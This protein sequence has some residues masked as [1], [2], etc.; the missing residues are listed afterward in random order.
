MATLCACGHN[1]WAHQPNCTACNSGI[2]RKF[3]A[4]SESED[5]ESDFEVLET[6]GAHLESIAGSLELIARSLGELVRN[7]DK[8]GY[9]DHS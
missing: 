9:R 6:I 5:N 4:V 3:S 7:T 8:S 2:C 1:Q